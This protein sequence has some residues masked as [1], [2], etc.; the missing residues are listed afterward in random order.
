MLIWSIFTKVPVLLFYPI[1]MQMYVLIF[2]LLY[3]FY[4]Y[5]I[6]LHIYLD[7]L[8]CSETVL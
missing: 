7:F 6:K 2:Y 8:E 3:L 5:R 4:L 1:V